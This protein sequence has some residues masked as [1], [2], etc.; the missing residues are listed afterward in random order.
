MKKLSLLLL[1]MTSIAANQGFDSRFQWKTD[2]NPFQV[3][4]KSARGEALLKHSWLNDSPYYNVFETKKAALACDNFKRVVFC[5]EQGSVAI[6]HFLKRNSDK[7][8]VIVPP[9]GADIRHVVRFA[10][11]FK[12]YDLLVL[13]YRTA[14]RKGL[15]PQLYSFLTALSPDTLERGSKQVQLALSFLHGKNYSEVIGCVQCYGSW[16][17]LLA[18]EECESKGDRGFDKLIVDS[19]PAGATELREKFIEDP[20]A[21]STFG[22][23][24]GPSYLTTVT[25]S[26]LVKNFFMNV[27]S[28]LFAEVSIADV[29][30]NITVPILFFHGSKDLLVDMN[31]FEKMYEAVGHT[32]KCSLLTPYKHLHHSLKSKELYRAMVLA[33]VEGTF[34]R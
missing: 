16:L 29:L 11:I 8:V 1:V 23:R 2:S 19:C 27:S 31:Q 15:F 13:E 33:F 24:Q 21:V 34:F 26:Y 14:S 28:K 5:V 30:K 7:V 20:V 17:A 6:G 18:Q 9:Y 3:V 10:G 32:Q 25:G 4:R 22:Q 12:E